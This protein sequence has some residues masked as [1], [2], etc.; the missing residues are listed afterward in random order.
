M[1]HSSLA[2]LGPA[3]ALTHVEG[4]AQSGKVVFRRGRR[5]Q[6]QNSARLRHRMRNERRVTGL[7]LALE[8]VEASDNLERVLQHAQIVTIDECV[9]IRTRDATSRATR[10][11]VVEQT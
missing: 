4:R 8:S 7:A 10:D 6:S 11:V 9:G 1:R 5:Q 2:P 3:R